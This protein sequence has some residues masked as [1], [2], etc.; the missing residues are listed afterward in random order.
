MKRAILFAAVICVLI[1]GIVWTLFRIAEPPGVVA[2]V[3]SVTNDAS[4]MRHATIRVVNE[5]RRPVFLR[6]I[7]ALQNRP[8]LWRTNQV[9]TNAVFQGTNLMGV[10]SFHPRSTG[11]KPGGSDEVTLPLPFDGSGW[12]ASFWYDNI[13]PRI[14]PQRTLEEIMRSW[15]IRIRSVLGSRDEGHQTMAYTDWNE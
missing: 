10:L 14:K 13:E 11:L 5:G 8:G 2:K 9:P 6:P 12:R 15:S 7:Y 1:L 4:G 3:S